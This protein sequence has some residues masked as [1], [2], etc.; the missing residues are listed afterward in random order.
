VYRITTPRNVDAARN[1]DHAKTIAK[2]EDFV[3]S[4][5]L[6]RRLRK[7]ANIVEVQAR[8]SIIKSSLASEL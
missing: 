3:K 6:R 4:K 8:T 1:N 5:D 7:S 2:A